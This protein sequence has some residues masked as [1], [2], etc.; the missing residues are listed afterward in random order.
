MSINYSTPH[1]ADIPVTD[2]DDPE[3]DII[4]HEHHRKHN[5]FEL[6]HDN[7]L[8]GL[9]YENSYSNNLNEGGGFITK[10]KRLFTNNHSRGRGNDYEMIQRS[11]SSV[12]TPDRDYDNDD[13]EDDDY[14]HQY[15][16][17]QPPPI[18]LRDRRLRLLENQVKNRTI[19]GGVTILLIAIV[20]LVLYLTKSNLAIGG[21][22][23]SSNYQKKTF[24]NST[25]DF[26]PTTIL[27]SLDGFHPHYINPQDTPTLHNM[28]INDYGAPY[29]TPSFPSSTFPNHWTLV[30]G[31]YPSEHGIVGNT[32]WDPKLKKQFINTDP[33]KGGLDPDFWRGG[34]PIWKTAKLQGLKSAVHMW[35]GSEVPHIGPD[36]DYD[37]FVEGELLSAKVDRLMEWLDREIEDR[38]ELI[39]TYVP[40]VDQYG[41]LYGISGDNLT[42]SLTYVD[43]FVDLVKGELHNRNLD[44]IVNL[45][46]VSDHGMAPTSKDR[47]LYLDDLID[48]AKIEHIDGWPLF[49][50]RP[51]GNSEET[52]NEL[53]QNFSKLD[54]EVT[55]NYQLYKV[56]DIPKRLQFG[57]SLEDHRYNYRL[58]PIWLFPNVGYAIT[59]HQKMKDDGYE[60]KPK[61]VHGYD[62]SHLLMRAI[63]LADG[64]YFKE[65]FHSK[66]VQPFANTEV[67]NIICDTLNLVS[68][69][70]NGTMNINI[71]ASK[72]LPSDWSDELSFPDLPFEVEHIVRNNATYDQLWRKG[73]KGKPEDVSKNPNPSES[74]KSKESSLT[75]FESQSIP[76][77]S[78]FEV[79][80]TSDTH[81]VITT[82]TATATTTLHE[83]FGGF[84]G[85]IIE[86]IEDSVDSI[87]DAIH[88]FIEDNFNN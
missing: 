36:K 63:F 59:T 6:D 52:Y 37:K 56:E 18:D 61:G 25:H 4:F 35:P 28:M 57:G 15:E 32:F 41:H 27:I 8:T 83:G 44:D 30:T 75:S 20:I 14:E 12:E 17:D 81:T 19:I 69:P 60:Y 73:N 23:Q 40:T 77:P 47:V 80:V 7:F 10:F 46:I 43:N 87:G 31:L 54:P 58:A 9:D 38:P 85:D 74:I 53:V 62:N 88:H 24:S 29:M 5:S 3:D 48:L 70:N 55:K 11:E 67:Y 84:I 78:D 16:E 71:I 33:K 76:K 39:L 68:S 42:Q 64:P 72:E 51:K 49:G 79:T 34:E 22:A 13:E 66:K 50:L 1:A 45:I 65:K 82:T 21:K 2:M 86:E 26:Y